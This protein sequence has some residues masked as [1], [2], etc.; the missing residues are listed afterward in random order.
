MV[1]EILDIQNLFNNRGHVVILVFGEASAKYN[2]FFVL[3]QSVVLLSQLV[4][5]VVVDGVIGLLSFGPFR[6]EFF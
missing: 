6:R 4:V 2:I 3:G 5:G 1:L